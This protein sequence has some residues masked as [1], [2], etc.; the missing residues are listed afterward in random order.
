MDE[1]LRSSVN[2]DD[3]INDARM[4]AFGDGRWLVAEGGGQGV[5]RWSVENVQENN[6]GVNGST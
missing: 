1:P 2:V 3:M 4:V 5:L 6:G